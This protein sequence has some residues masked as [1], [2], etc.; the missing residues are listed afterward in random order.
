MSSVQGRD[1]RRIQKSIG[2]SCSWINATESNSAVSAPW[3]VEQER[4]PES[5]SV[6]IQHFIIVSL[7]YEHTLFIK[8]IHM[9]QQSFTMQGVKQ[10]DV[11]L[12]RGNPIQ[13]EPCDPVAGKINQQKPQQITKPLQAS[14]MGQRCRV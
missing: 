9:N 2:L 4:I 5:R 14:V 6:K 8:K 10:R 3:R 12:H 7:K 11:P 1:F 13:T